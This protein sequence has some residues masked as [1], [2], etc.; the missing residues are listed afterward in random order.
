VGA[1]A[2]QLQGEGSAPGTSAQNCYN[3]RFGWHIASN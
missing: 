2:I 3:G 1:A